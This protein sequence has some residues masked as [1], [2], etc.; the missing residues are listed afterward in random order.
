MPAINSVVAREAVSH[1]VKRRKN[2]AHRQPGVILVF[3]IVF[4]I[5]VGLLSLFVHRKLK[6]R[7]ERKLSG[8]PQ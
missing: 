3:C 2:W 8:K 4:I 6:A 1:L 5:G 7:K